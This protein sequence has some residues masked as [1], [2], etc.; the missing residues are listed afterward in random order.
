MPL[1]KSPPN[2]IVNGVPWC[3]SRGQV[4]SAHGGGILHHQGAYYWYGEHHRMGF[5]NRVGVSC[6]RSADLCRWEYLGLALPKENLPEC[7][8]DQGVCE[9]PKVLYCAATGKF[10]MWM[11]LDAEGYTHANAGVATADRPEGPFQVLRIF[12]PIAHDYPRGGLDGGGSA[13]SEA[14]R[15][16]LATIDEAGRGNTFRDMNLFLDSRGQAWVFYAAENNSTLYVSRLQDDFTDVVRPP[17]LG[18]TWARTHVGRWR[19]APAPFEFENRFYLFSSGCTGWNPNP[20]L[21]SVAESPLGPWRELG[22][23][24]RGPGAETS[25]RSQPACVLP[26][27]GGSARTFLYLGD[28]WSASDIRQA[29]YVWLP[30]RFGSDASLALEYL[31]AWSPA[32]LSAAPVPLD[33]PRVRVSAGPAAVAP[34][35]VWPRVPGADFHRLY[36]NNEYCGTVVDQ[37]FV[38]PPQFPGQAVAWTVVAA[39]LAGATSPAS[40]PVLESCC[41]VPEKAWLSDYPPGRAAQGFGSLGRDTNVQQGPLRIAGRSF[42]KGL[43]T[44][45]HSELVYRIGGGFGSFEAALGLDDSHQGGSVEFQVYGDDRLLF[46]SGLVRGGSAARRIRVPIAG[47]MELKL[48]VTDGGDGNHCDHANWAAALLRR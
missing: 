12:R 10:V 47:V 13:S 3:D 4:L 23:P 20:L 43:G 28:R 25:F 39:S 41:E 14:D 42:R 19:E 22:N 2:L 40:D 16:R 38:P 1:R 29:T 36:R 31:P 24:C 48:V 9:R 33:P 5:G 6:Y 8:R 37:R 34:A 45:A 7:Y 18:Q 27:P 26:A 32:G 17:V 46:S 21:L 15:Q 30:F 44:H 11:H 35:L